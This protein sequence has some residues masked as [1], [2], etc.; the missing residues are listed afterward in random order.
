MALWGGARTTGPQRKGDFRAG[1]RGTAVPRDV[2]GPMEPPPQQFAAY[3]EPPPGYPVNNP[4][5]W[6][7]KYERPEG[8]PAT[9]FDSYPDPTRPPE[10]WYAPQDADKKQRHSVESIDTDGWAELKGGSGYPRARNPREV[11]PPEDRPTMKMAPRNYTFLRPFDQWNRQYGPA[12]NA[13]VNSSRQLNGTHF[14]MAGFRRDYPILGMRPGSTS[15]RN[16][17]RLTPAPWDENIVDM[18]PETGQPVNVT[19][20]SMDVPPARRSYRLG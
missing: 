6:A 16:T 13:S 18:P 20:R 17:F 9:R 1:T 5:G 11:P 8:N 4:L 3:S 12:A 10:N 19:I 14:S 15:R 2:M 7:P